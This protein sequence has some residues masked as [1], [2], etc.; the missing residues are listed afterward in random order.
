MFQAFCFAEGD[1]EFGQE[2][3]K[4]AI[5]IIKGPEKTVRKIIA[6]ECPIGTFSGVEKPFIKSVCSA[7]FHR[8]SAG[9][10][11]GEWLEKQHEKYV[12]SLVD[13][14]QMKSDDKG[15]LEKS[16]V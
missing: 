14:S 3:P 10:A 16:D 12:D 9:D 7:Q 2:V 6:D 1:I 13:F 4:G 15:P 11:L 5:G 8:Q